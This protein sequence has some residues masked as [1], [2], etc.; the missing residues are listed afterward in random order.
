MEYLTPL[1]FAT[2]G[3]LLL[4]TV[5]N[6][7]PLISVPLILCGAVAYY[8]SPGVVLLTVGGVAVYPLDLVAIALASGA[9]L[10]VLSGHRIAAA[11][12]W[13]G[14]ALLVLITAL[15]GV[16]VYG[17]VEV[18][19]AVRGWGQFLAAA[20][21]VSSINPSEDSLTSLR[22]SWTVASVFAMTLSFVFLAQQGLQTFSQEGTRPLH[23]G[24]ASIV[25]QALLIWMVAKEPKGSFLLRAAVIIGSLTTILLSGQRTVWAVTVVSLIVISLGL[26]TSSEVI[27]R[28]A[29]VV[30][31]TGAIAAMILF[32]IRPPQLL[33]GLDFALAEATGE[34]STFSWRTEGWAVLT[35]RQLSSPLLDLLMGAPAGSGFERL[36]GEGVVTVAPHSFYVFLLVSTGL[37]GLGVV[38]CFYVWLFRRLRTAISAG[39]P[40]SE[41]AVV[42]AI[43]L[44]GQLVYSV[45]Y[46]LGIE[47]ALLLGLATT[48][49]SRGSASV[50]PD[51]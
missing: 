15:R 6:E 36:V 51:A 19:E 4:A 9:A 28:R 45:S 20:V 47:Q 5:L 18:G 23:A 42:S 49:A 30:F 17:F 27:V 1:A 21:F 33:G 14:L 41:V 44:V 11:P 32:L 26:F 35:A 12:V 10:R 25:T 38:V 34:R 22:R 46:E 31:A 8:W 50:R 16:G 2:V 7:R 40:Q 29:R 43:L 48:V 3:L 37:I 13:T 39:S 24:Q